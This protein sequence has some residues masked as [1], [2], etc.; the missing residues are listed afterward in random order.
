MQ[1]LEGC[2][3]EGLCTQ[4]SEPCATAV[5]SVGSPDHWQPEGSAAPVA[6][7]RCDRN[8]QVLGNHI[9]Y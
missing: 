4:T 8:D 9:N 1:Q 2:V 3:C 7:C 5:L 6:S